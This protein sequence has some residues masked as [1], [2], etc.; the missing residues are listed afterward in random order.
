ATQ[1]GQ[2]LHVALEEIDILRTVAAELA[3]MEGGGEPVLVLFGAPGLLLMPVRPVDRLQGPPRGTLPR[4]TGQVRQEDHVPAEF[5]AVAASGAHDQPS[6]RIG[7]Y[8]QR[9]NGLPIPHSPGEDTLQLIPAEDLEAVGAERHPGH[10]VFVSLESG[11]GPA[12]LDVP[13]AHRPVT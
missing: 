5:G 4:G 9:W 3:E 13:Q 1:F 2:D 6:R 12:S 8:L 10:Q 7:R 11:P